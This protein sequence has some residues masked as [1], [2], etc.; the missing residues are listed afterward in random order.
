MRTDCFT[1]RTYEHHSLAYSRLWG[2]TATL[3][4]RPAPVTQVD[5]A[6]RAV[7]TSKNNA[8][9]N[10]LDGTVSFVRA[11]ALSFAEEAA[12][13]GQVWDLVVVDPPSFL[14]KSA[15]STARSFKR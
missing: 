11:E 15:R 5:K 2:H 1:F 7:R 8:A 4:P 9:A 13:L 14:T 10:G 3:G 6:A 12:R